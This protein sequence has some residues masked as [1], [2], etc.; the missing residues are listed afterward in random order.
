MM[1]PVFVKGSIAFVIDQHRL[2]FVHQHISTWGVSG[3]PWNSAV[4]PVG[5]ATG[6]TLSATEHF[7]QKVDL[8]IT[9]Q[10][11]SEE[12]TLSAS[13]WIVREYTAFSEAMGIRFDLS[14]T[15]QIQLDEF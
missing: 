4:S 14:P 12:L 10:Q 6:V 13:G 11:D 8:T 15:Q 2:E 1:K 5:Q 3:L 7:G 9:I